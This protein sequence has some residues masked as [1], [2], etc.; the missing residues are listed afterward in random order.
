[1]TAA[2][3]AAATEDTAEY[4]LEH[5][6]A[7]SKKNRAVIRGVAAGEKAPLEV[8]RT[9]MDNLGML[10]GLVEVLVGARETDEKRNESDQD[11]S[12]SGI[13]HSTGGTYTKLP[14][15]ALLKRSGN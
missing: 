10:K 2:A 5:P 15:R 11:C 13:D 9:G 4:D 6:A 3:G 1:M 14:F 7:V 8:R 12:G